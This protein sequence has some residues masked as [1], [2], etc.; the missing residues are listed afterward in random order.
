[1]PSVGDGGVVSEATRRS[2]QG[3]IFGALGPTAPPAASWYS[4]DPKT[5]LLGPQVSCPHGKQGSLAGRGP[6]G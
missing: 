1:M 4:P 2:R 6:H 3:G 5:A